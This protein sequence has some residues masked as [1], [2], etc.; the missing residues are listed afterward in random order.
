MENNCRFRKSQL[1][2]F[3]AAKPFLSARYSFRKHNEYFPSGLCTQRWERELWVEKVIGLLVGHIHKLGQLF[4]VQ[5]R[6]TMTE[7]GTYSLIGATINRWNW[8]REKYPSC[9]EHETSTYTRIRIQRNIC[10]PCAYQGEKRI[11][12]ILCIM[13]RKKKEMKK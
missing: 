1:I 11:K 8:P 3:A 9:E 6:A 5:M 4:F 2:S 12:K 7:S 13:S 10:D